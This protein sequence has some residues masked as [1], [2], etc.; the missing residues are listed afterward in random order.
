VF[1]YFNVDSWEGCEF[2][3]TLSVQKQ[4]NGAERNDLVNW[5]NSNDPK[6]GL[7]SLTPAERQGSGVPF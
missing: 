3:A 4:N 7:A 1:S 2:V 6:K 5:A